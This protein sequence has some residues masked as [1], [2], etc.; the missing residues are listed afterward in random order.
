MKAN[1]D[2]AFGA[3]ADVYTNSRDGGAVGEID[4]HDDEPVVMGEANMDSSS[5]SGSDGEETPE[6]QAN[7]EAGL[8]RAEARA[9]KS[10]PK[11]ALM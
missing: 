8:K 6:D 7:Y 1:P 10:K 9:Q 3:G 2:K 5:D 4:M 11:N